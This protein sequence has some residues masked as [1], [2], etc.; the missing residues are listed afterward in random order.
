MTIYYDIDHG[1]IVYDAIDQLNGACTLTL[2][3]RHES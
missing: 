2:S 1:I 3:T